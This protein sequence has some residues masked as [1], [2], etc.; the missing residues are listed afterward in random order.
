VVVHKLH[1]LQDYAACIRQH[2]DELGGLHKDLLISA[3]SFFR[4]PKAVEALSRRLRDLMARNTAKDPLRI[5]VPGWATGEEAY[6]IAIL[7]AEI[8]GAGANKPPVQIFATDV[9]E[10]S[11][12]LARKRIYPIA[13]VMDIDGRRF[14]KYFSQSDNRVRVNKSIRDMVLLARQDLI[15]DTPFLHLD[16]IS[17]RN[18]M[19]YLNDELQHKLLS[20]FHFSLNPGGLLLLGMPESINQRADLFKSIDARWRIYRRNDVP[21]AR[22]PELL[23]SRCMSHPASAGAGQLQQPHESGALRDRVFVDALLGVMDCCAL[24]TDDHANILYI[25]GSGRI[26]LAESESPCQPYRRQPWD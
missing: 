26:R 5:W 21:V 6:S 14:E 7:A 19:I 11:V 20:L 10:G 24:L 12:Q 3:T 16:L 17:C 9:D 25:R 23:Q 18:L 1:S 2:P 22:L 4:D 8:S 13:T 15:Q